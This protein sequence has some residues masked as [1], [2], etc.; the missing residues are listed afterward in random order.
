MLERVLQEIVKISDGLLFFCGLDTNCRGE[1]AGRERLSAER[2]IS[3]YPLERGS[4][5]W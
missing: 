4:R 5:G 3:F 1:D 2:F